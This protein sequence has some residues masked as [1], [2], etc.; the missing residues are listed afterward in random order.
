[1]KT[2]KDCPK[3]GGGRIFHSPTITDR[4]EGWDK[5]LALQVKGLIFKRGVGELEAFVCA[6]CG[7]TELYVSDIEALRHEVES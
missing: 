1:M 3:C 6:G 5:N 7:Y 2:G 4:N